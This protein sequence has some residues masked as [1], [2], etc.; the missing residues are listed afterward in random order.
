[1]CGESSAEY[2]RLIN[3][4]TRDRLG[5]LRSADCLLRSVDFSQLEQLQP[6]GRWDQAGLIAG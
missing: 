1:M 3:E 6:P 5:G 4:E 2:Y